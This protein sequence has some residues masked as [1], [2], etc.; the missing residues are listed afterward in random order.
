MNTQRRDFLKALGTA[1]A[2]A[3][4]PG[5]ATM[6]PASGKVVVVGGG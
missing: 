5:C 2:F 6:G 4:I 3:A 1:S